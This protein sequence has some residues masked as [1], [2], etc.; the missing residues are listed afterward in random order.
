MV[1]L[2][3]LCCF[4]F[5]LFTDWYGE[6]PNG[7]AR[8]PKIGSAAAHEANPEVDVITSTQPFPLPQGEAFPEPSFSWNTVRQFAKESKNVDFET[9]PFGVTES[10]KSP[11]RSGHASPVA[12]DDKVILMS[13]GPFGVELSAYEL[14][15]GSEVWSRSLSEAPVTAKH[16]KGAAVSSTPTVADR[17]VIA[18]WSDSSDVWMVGLEGNGS[19]RWRYHVGPTNSQWG[20]NA[21]PVT[22]R[23]LV[24]VNI[25][26]E[27][28]G[29][30]VALNVASG[31][32]VW[33]QSRPD[34]YEGSYSSP[35]I[36]TEESGNAIVVLSGLQSVVAMDA[37]SGVPQWSLPAVSDVSAATPIYESG[38]LVASSGY[39]RHHL[40]AMEFR[41]GIQRAPQAVWAASKPS[42]VPY[43]PTPIIRE[44]VLYVVQDDGIAQATDLQSQKSL[45]RKRLGFA[46]TSSPTWIEG[47]IFVCGEAGQCV[48]LSPTTGD[49][50]G[51]LELRESI[52]ASPTVI[53]SRLLVRTKESLCCFDL[54]AHAAIDQST[55]PNASNVSSSR[56]Q[57]P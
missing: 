28:G 57:K 25:D 1:L 33:R 29:N 17:T 10:W 52:F 7:V 5:T 2:V 55:Q 32:L 35:L 45:W 31:D 49:K 9:K 11:S 24:Y 36:V 27:Y 20:F 53:G 50:T 6:Q 42:E 19:E 46:V 30:V 37:A 4:C 39:R 26:N 12:F 44:G 3:V 15:T 21:S 8:K 23:G 40:I 38:F 22:Y 51:E 13:G 56:F 47:A 48:A 34:G 54:T 18:C 14:T 43:V 41:N 16:S